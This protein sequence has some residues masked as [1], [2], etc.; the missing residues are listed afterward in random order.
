MSN[1]D[2][3]QRFVFVK[4]KGLHLGYLQPSRLI[5][6]CSL[7]LE[8]QLINIIDTSVLKQMISP[9]HHQQVNLQILYSD[10]RV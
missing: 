7:Q 5:H 1:V 6:F 10:L 3:F 8:S 9:I 4:R 2:I